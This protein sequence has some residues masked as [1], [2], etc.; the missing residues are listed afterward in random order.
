MATNG[1]MI[2]EISICNQALT[3]LGQKPIVSFADQSTTAEWMR[4][5]YEFL[6]DAV[7]EERSWTFA[8]V[9]ATTTVA[10]VS[11]FGG[12]YDH[13][14][15][16][17]WLWVSRV[18]KNVSARD[19]N[20]W[21]MDKTWRVEGEFIVSAHPTIYTMGVQRISDTGK[22]SL[23]FVQALAA[24]LAADAAVPLTENRQLQVDLWGLYQDKLMAAAAR[25][26]Q[27]GS[28]DVITQR[29]LTGIR[30]TGGRSD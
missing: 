30:L 27:Q 15:Q 16:L 21:V 12:M 25:D 29:H 26:G 18:W 3:W 13:P 7:L 1:P 23:L 2:S 9:K 19:P 6:R 11:V 8:T 4:N 14:K 28:N 10:D 22:F 5:N 20:N 24:R 17:N